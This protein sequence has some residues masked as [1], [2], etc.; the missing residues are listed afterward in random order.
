MNKTLVT[1]LAGLAV[2]IPALALADAPPKPGKWAEPMTKSAVEARVKEHFARLDANGDGFVTKAEADAA[3]EKFAAAMKDRRFKAI[4]KNNDGSIS[5]EEFD[6]PREARHAKL[7]AAGESDAKG[8]GRRMHRGGHHRG[9]GMAMMGGGM[10]ERADA[11]KDGR[12]SFAEALARPMEHFQKMDA[13]NDGTVSPEER[14][15]AHEKMREAWRAKR[16]G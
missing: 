16:A 15:A 11:D 13:N 10:F 4:D 8:E 9:M 7:A 12:V 2:A 14:K 1:A 6:A 5:R 3:H